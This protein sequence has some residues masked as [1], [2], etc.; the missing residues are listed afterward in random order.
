VGHHPFL[1]S[2]LVVE[3]CC[4]LWTWIRRVPLSAL[5]TFVC[6]DR[7]PIFVEQLGDVPLPDP[8]LRHQVV[9]RGCFGAGSS[10]ELRTANPTSFGEVAEIVNECETLAWG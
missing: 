1:D 5:P 2:Q 4:A 7:V 9:Q 10:A 8:L 6:F 3:H